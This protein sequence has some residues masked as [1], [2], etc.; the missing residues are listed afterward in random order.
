MSEQ[1]TSDADKAVVRSK[2][3]EERNKAHAEKMSLYRERVKSQRQLTRNNWWREW[4]A[5]GRL[6]VLF[7]KSLCEI[8]I[9]VLRP[10]VVDGKW[11]GKTAEC[12][13]DGCNFNKQSTDA[14][15]LQMLKSCMHI[16][17]VWIKSGDNQ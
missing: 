11:D 7:Q 10:K 3:R 16:Y 13:A 12:V 17:D 15:E 14:T 4:E 9:H 6:H 8:G 1:P 2:A 5:S